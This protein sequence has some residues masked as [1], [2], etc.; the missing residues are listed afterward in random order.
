MWSKSTTSDL[1]LKQAI[2][3]SKMLEGKKTRIAFC[4]HDSVVLD[5]SH[6]DKAMIKDIAQTFSQ[7]E[8]G[9]YFVNISIGKDFGRMRTVNI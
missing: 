7:T 6:E 4:L 1:T 8:L 9:K 2:K 5:M 3:L